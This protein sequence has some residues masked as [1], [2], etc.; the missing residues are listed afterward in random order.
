MLGARH[1]L[2][3]T[4]CTVMLFSMYTLLMWN[5]DKISTLQFSLWTQHWCLDGFSSLPVVSSKRHGGGGGRVSSMTSVMAT[6]SNVQLRTTDHSYFLWR[7]TGT[8]GRGGGEGRLC[9]LQLHQQWK[10]TL[11]SSAAL[12]MATPS[13]ELDAG[14][15]GVGSTH[16]LRPPCRL[17]DLWCCKSLCQTWYRIDFSIFQ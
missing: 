14:R 17:I 11:A 10:L 8:W 1:T 9:V 2:L 6:F 5:F 15:K 3:W 7:S 4:L 16:C 13:I 12:T